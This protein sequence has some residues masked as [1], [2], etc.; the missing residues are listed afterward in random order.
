[1]LRWIQLDQAELIA[2]DAFDAIVLGEP[3]IEKRVIRIKKFHDAAIVLDDML[4]KA[5]GLLAHRLP[6][7][8]VKIGKQLWDR[9]WRCFRAARCSHCSAK[10]SVSARALGSLSM[11]RTCSS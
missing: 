6:Q 10:F 8:F 3:L 9:A 7:R 4:D 1:M 11:R 5:L 2:A